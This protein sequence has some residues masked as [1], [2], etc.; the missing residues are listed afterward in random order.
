VHS[1]KVDIKEIEIEVCGQSLAHWQQLPN[2]YPCQPHED[3]DPA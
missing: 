3:D 1:E 2:G